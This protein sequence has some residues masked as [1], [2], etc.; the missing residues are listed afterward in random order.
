MA[1][2]ILGREVIAYAER[3]IAPTLSAGLPRDRA[4]STP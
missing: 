4:F 3:A 1:A 2:S